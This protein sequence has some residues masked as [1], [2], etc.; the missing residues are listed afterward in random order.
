MQL[1]ERHPDTGVTASPG[2]SVG[3]END[4]TKMSGEE[5]PSKMP[6]FDKAFRY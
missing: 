4:C 3:V 1:A 2:I 6:S 5:S